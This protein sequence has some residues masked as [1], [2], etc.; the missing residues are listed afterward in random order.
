[1]RIQHPRAAKGL[2]PPA[3]VHVAQRDTRPVD[4]EGYFECPD[5]KAPAIKQALARKYDVEFEGGE[6]VVDEDVG[7]APAEENTDEE[8]SAADEEDVDEFDLATFLEQGYTDRADAVEAGEVDAHL[9]A[10]EDA[11]TSTTVTDAID[12]RRTELADAEE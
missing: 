9:D 4:D 7:E 8:E 6:V 11:E 2:T 3:R 10:I 5:A 12:D 1:M